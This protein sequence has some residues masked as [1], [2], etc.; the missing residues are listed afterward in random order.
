M[1]SDGALSADKAT[2][3]AVEELIS[4]LVLGEVT[5]GTDFLQGGSSAANLDAQMDG[6]K[7]CAN[8]NSGSAETTDRSSAELLNFDNKELEGKTRAAIP[9]ATPGETEAGSK[10][11]LSDGVLALESEGERLAKQ[12]TKEQEIVT[13]SEVVARMERIDQRSRL[14]LREELKSE[15]EDA[16]ELE[17]QGEE[18]VSQTQ[19][20][21]LLE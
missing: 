3:G 19:R 8:P 15:V 4:E 21:F 5:A 16:G 9:S 1:A 13:S 11:A 12:K 14:G 20:D 18:E 2:D 7:Q 6:E 17:K 10:G